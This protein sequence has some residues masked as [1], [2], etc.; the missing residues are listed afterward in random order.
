MKGLAGSSFVHNQQE[1]QDQN[2][3][4]KAPTD[5]D[6]DHC[7]KGKLG[8]VYELFPP[9]SNRQASISGI[10]GVTILDHQTLAPHDK[11]YFAPSTGFENLKNSSGQFLIENKRYHQQTM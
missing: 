1:L 5:L 7:S 11:G 4:G 2:V 10:E 3:G 6:L 9:E 8:V